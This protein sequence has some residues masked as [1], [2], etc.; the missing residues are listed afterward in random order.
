MRHLKTF[1]TF[2]YDFIV[3]DDWRLAAGIVI[4]L[5][6]GFLSAHHGVDPWWALPVAVSALLA[7]STTDAARRVRVSSTT[8]VTGPAGPVDGA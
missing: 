5:A 4:V 6:A 7:V 8:A 3:G 1:G 2:W